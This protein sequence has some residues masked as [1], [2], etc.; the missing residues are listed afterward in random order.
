MADRTRS[1]TRRT[2]IKGFGATAMAGIAGCIGGGG[3]GVPTIGLATTTMHNELAATYYS[4]DYIRDNILEHVGEEYEVEYTNVG[5]SPV[6]VSSVGS[7][8]AQI[9][10]FAFSSSASAA[11][12]GAVPPGFTILGGAIWIGVDDYYSH[13]TVSAGDSDITEPADI[14]GH[15]LAVNSRGAGVDINARKV[16]AD[17]G[18]EAG[19]DYEIRELSFGAIPD[20]VLEGRVDTGVLIQPFWYMNQDDMNGIFD[21]SQAQEDQ[22]FVFYA[23]RNDFLEENTE[24]VEYW[25]EDVWTA[26]EWWMHDGPRDQ[27]LEIA[28]DVAGYADRQTAEDFVG[29]TVDYYKGQDGLGISVDNL[30]RS[31]DLMEEL[32]FLDEPLD[33]GEY[34][35]NSYLP[36]G[37]QN[38]L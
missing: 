34:V 18:L 3:D 20:A 23:I 26:H 27:V 31:W 1:V 7:D 15:S 25:L 10:G 6:A 19:E 17:N 38:T 29:T 14:E 16:L 9:G 30:Q 36:D 2:A 37:A 8:D 32:G 12:E 33:A 28:V 22:P 21:A 35:D 4:S 11:Q 24:A 13:V 5:G